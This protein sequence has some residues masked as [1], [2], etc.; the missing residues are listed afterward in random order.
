MP[1]LSAPVSRSSLGRG[2]AAVLAAGALATAGAVAPAAAHD[3]RGGAPGPAPAVTG[4]G[5]GTGTGTDGAHGGD[6]RQEQGRYRG[7]VTAE[8]LALRTSPARGSDVIRYARRGEVVSI[9]CKTPGDTVKGN[10]LWYLL[11]DGTWAWGAARYID[12]VGPAP[13]WC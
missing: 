3:G 9:Y 12:N 4:T 2:L 8:R 13:R 10:P 5:T 11:T 6:G 7:V 1:Q